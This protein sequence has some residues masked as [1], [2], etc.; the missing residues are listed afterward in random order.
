MMAVEILRTSSV[1]CREKTVN[2][3]R[4]SLHPSP[5]PHVVHVVTDTAAA[6]AALASMVSCAKCSGG[7][8]E[9]EQ[10]RLRSGDVCHRQLLS[11]RQPQLWRQRQTRPSVRVRQAGVSHSH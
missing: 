7:E 2:K 9:L 10:D 5:H 1:Q 6:A 4:W 3:H 8:V 11:V